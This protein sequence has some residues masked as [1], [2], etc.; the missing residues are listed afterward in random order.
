M[1]EKFYVVATTS[2]NDNIALLDECTTRYEADCM[3]NWHNSHS[4]LYADNVTLE[5]KSSTELAK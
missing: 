2:D 5:V 3:L 1:N 4:W